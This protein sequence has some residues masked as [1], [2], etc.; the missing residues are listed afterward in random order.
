LRRSAVKA[1]GDVEPDFAAIHPAL[2]LQAWEP[3]FPVRRGKV[4]VGG[5]KGGHMLRA[6]DGIA[7]QRVR[8]VV[9]GQDP[10]PDPTLSTDRAFQAGSVAAWRELEKMFSASMR[11]SLQ[12]IVAARTDN[13]GYARTTQ[14]WR[15]VLAEIEAG[16]LP[17][18]NAATL[19]DRWVRSGVLLLNAPF[20]ITRL[21][22]AGDPHPMLGHLK[23][24]RPV[25]QVVL[26]HFAA[27]G[28]AALALDNPFVPANRHLARHGVAPIDW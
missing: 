23:L 2:E 26:R 19:I 11:T 8:C 10:Y 16:P 6:F 18:E 22:V 17:F 25:A 1:L 12:Q 15:R 5:P 13:A 21:Q 20:T 3:M 14:G 9:L 7:P 28:D 24:S 4:L 27:R